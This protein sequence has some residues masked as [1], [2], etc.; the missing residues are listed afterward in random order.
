GRPIYERG[1]HHVLLNEISKRELI[2][3]IE[4]TGLILLAV[5][6]P[7]AAFVAGGGIAA[8]LVHHA[9]ERRHLYH[10]LIDPSL[11]LNRAEVELGVYIA[12]AALALALLPEAGMAIKA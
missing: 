2:G 7:P 8:Y 1:I 6:C 9:L 5:I 11:V 3:F 12:Y 10:W 4:F